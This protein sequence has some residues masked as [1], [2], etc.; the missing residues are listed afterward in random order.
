MSSQPRAEAV[1]CAPRMIRPACGV[2]AISSLSS[3]RVCE[4]CSRSP[5]AS[6][7]AA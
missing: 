5:R 4:R 6:P 2:V 3:P 7:F 1:S